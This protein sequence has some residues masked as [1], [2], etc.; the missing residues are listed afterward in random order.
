M[1]LAIYYHVEDE[2]EIS[3]D[4]SLEKMKNEGLL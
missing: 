4:R 1:Q 3:I 2:L